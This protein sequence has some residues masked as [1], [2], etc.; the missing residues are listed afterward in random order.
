MEE[1]EVCRNAGKTNRMDKG[2]LDWEKF[3]FEEELAFSQQQMDGEN[4]IKKLQLE[5]RKT[6]AGVH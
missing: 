4:E 1:R 6:K 3:K 5:K 2:K